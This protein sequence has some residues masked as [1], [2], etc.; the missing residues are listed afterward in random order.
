MAALI[1]NNNDL[2]TLKKVNFTQYK[3]LKLSKS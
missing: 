1:L 3:D 2:L